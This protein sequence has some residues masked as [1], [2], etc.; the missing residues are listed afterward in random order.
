M[1]MGK[2]VADANVRKEAHD[3][4][5]QKLAANR[6]AVEVLD[7]AKNRTSKL[8]NPKTYKA[9]P[10]AIKM[11][12]DVVVPLEDEQTID[13]SNNFK[14]EWDI[15]TLIDEIVAREK[16]QIWSS[17]Q[18]LQCWSRDREALTTTLR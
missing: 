17:R 14:M 13:D 10:K 11:V 7:I 15:N 16:P 12:D 4:S 2:Q 18:K 5:G 6:A 8:Y 3:K 1:D 9:L